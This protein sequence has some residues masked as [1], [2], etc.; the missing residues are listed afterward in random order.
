MNTDGLRSADDWPGTDA[1]I[2][3]ARILFD[4]ALFKDD[5]GAL[6]EADLELDAVEADLALARGQI[7]HGRF[8]A[9]RTGDPRWDKEDPQELELFERAARLYEQWDDRRGHAEALF[10]IGCFH[11]VVRRDNETAVPLLERSLELA[12]LEDD[13]RTMSE[14]LRHLGIA[15]HGAGRLD[16]ARERLEES[17][18]L[19]REIG[20]LPGV[21][22]NLVGLSYIAAGQGRREDA[23][24]LI[25]E[26]TAIA[27]ANGDR[28]ILH[29]LEEARAAL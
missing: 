7:I 4:H 9:Q 19:R 25:E 11:Q 8:L 20:F 3:R 6:E 5:P 15:E 14:A 1:R 29:Q 28:G 26:A 13:K 18:R 16:Q 27:K 22:G 23:L 10:W 24:A 12:A 21:A 2:E 17:V